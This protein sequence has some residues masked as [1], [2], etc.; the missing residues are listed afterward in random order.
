MPY[1]V[2]SLYYDIAN[3]CPIS[4]IQHQTDITLVLKELLKFDLVELFHA[5][6]DLNFEV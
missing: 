5:K 4:S 2:H 6:F 1:T 3:E